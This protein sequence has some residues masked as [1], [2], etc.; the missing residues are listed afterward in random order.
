MEVLFSLT[1]TP[2]DSAP[3]Q[4]ASLFPR[5]QTPGISMTF[6]IGSPYPLEISYPLLTR[7]KS[8]ILILKVGT[9]IKFSR[10]YSCFYIV[11]ENSRRHIF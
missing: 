3:F 1:P 5:P 4:G 7:L 2:Q 10:S 9:V 6:L 11:D 8:F